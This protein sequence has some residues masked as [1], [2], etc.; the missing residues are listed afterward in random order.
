MRARIESHF[1]MQSTIRVSALSLAVLTLFGCA[2][3]P[4]GKRDPRDPFE[5]VNRTIYKFNDALD[6]AVAR[7]I[8]HTYRKVTPQ[9][10]QTGISNF[11]SNL[12]YPVVIVNDL[13]QGRF[14]PFAKDT[15][16]FVM[17]TTLG[18][19]GLLDPASSAGL[20]KNE[21]DF[22]QTLGRWGFKPGPYLMLPI[23]GPSDVRDGIGKVANT[24]TS[25]RQYIHDN[26]VYYTLYGLYFLDY[27]AS[28][29]PQEK[30]LDSAYDPYAFLRNAY[31][32]RRQFLI[33]GQGSGPS[34][35]EY[36]EQKLLDE[37]GAGEDEQP[38][39]GT[40]EQKPPQEQQPQKP[41]PESSP[42]KQQ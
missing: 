37:A 32:Q 21:N 34:D 19:G 14:K 36:Q 38:P 16:R 26:T 5:R 4:S 35:E 25:P 20:E 1:P 30:T 8:A 10:V 24:Y 31:L 18:I 13:L 15:G 17:N 40:E 7:P 27:R 3:L 6:K 29:V 28:L 42:P 39:K 2:S 12:D 22:G 23:L 9:F 41:E 33:S 11:N